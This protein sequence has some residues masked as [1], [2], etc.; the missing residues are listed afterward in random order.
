MEVNLGDCSLHKV[1]DRKSF[2]TKRSRMRRSPPGTGSGTSPAP[3]IWSCWR[4]VGKTWVFLSATFLQKLTADHR[5]LP[6]V[7]A[8]SQAA[9][10][11]TLRQQVNKRGASGTASSSGGCRASKSVAGGRLLCSSVQGLR[12]LLGAGLWFWSLVVPVCLSLSGVSCSETSAST[13]DTSEVS[14]EQRR[15]WNPWRPQIFPGKL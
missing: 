14:R 4:P 3:P 5:L 9:C 10:R 2:F 13:G 11:Q 6:G 12:V 8:P 15:E 7:D 1:P